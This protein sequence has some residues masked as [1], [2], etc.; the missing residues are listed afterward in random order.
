[1]DAAQTRL[2]ARQSIGDA[3]GMPSRRAL[4]LASLL[5]IA[6][7][8]LKATPKAV[9][10][11]PSGVGV[12]ATLDA[13]PVASVALDAGR[14]QPPHTLPTDAIAKLGPLHAPPIDLGVAWLVL[15]GP[16][17]GLRFAWLVADG[18]RPAPIDGFP[19]AARLVAHATMG[20]AAHLLLESVGV[21]DQ[22]AGL[23]AVVRVDADASWFPGDGLEM[24]LAD[25]GPSTLAERV[26]KRT[27]ASP[28]S[29]SLDA[30][31]A[32]HANGDWV[33]VTPN[34]V[35]AVLAPGGATIARMWQRTFTQ[36]TG[37]KVDAKSFAT[38]PEAPAIASL[39]NAE[40]TTPSYPDRPL[41]VPNSEMG[42]P[43][44][45]AIEVD[46]A[47]LVTAVHLHA[48]PDP[49]VK[50]VPAPAPTLGQP[51]APATLA[52]MP[53]PYDPAAI[54]RSAELSTATGTVAFASDD[55]ETTVMFVD[56]AFATARTLP[57][58]AIDFRFV[59][60]DG[61]GRVDL[62]LRS[63]EEPFRLFLA[64]R[65][66]HE[67]QDDW[68]RNLAMIGARD[69]DA[70]IAAARAVVR[71]GVDR[72]AACKL[73]TAIRSPAAFRAAATKRGAR[74]RFESPNDPIRAP[75]V[76]PAAKLTTDDVGALGAGCEQ[77]YC[78]AASPFCQSTH[79]GPDNEHYVFT[80][81]K[82][83]LRLL[84]ATAYT[85]S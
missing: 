78:D 37:K 70:A 62:L 44:L 5:A 61:D 58:T 69:F 3:R 79:Q 65:S 41:R 68:A 15:V 80:W 17:E 36:P 74:I 60:I 1:M 7:C 84:F 52:Q 47:G 66:V 2:D 9:G 21:L 25:A 67:R 31:L 53:W 27:S 48:F 81:E 64:R 56:G 19:T 14:R 50:P 12:V 33:A 29:T 40:A 35:P 49:V 71:R 23:R 20:H 11:P 32:R 82:G 38:A 22:P 63:N 30:R 59:D 13:G 76:I 26:R 39:L 85:G 75:F 24:D 10:M 57:G 42:S 6:A 72:R 34:D 55:V 4:G 16:K 54:Q 77:L 45:G 18:E 8:S 51:L 73:L 28:P 43:H 83:A 46:D